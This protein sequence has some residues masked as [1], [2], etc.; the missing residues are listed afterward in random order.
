VAGCVF[1]KGDDGNQ[2]DSKGNQPE[3]SAARNLYGPEGNE[4]IRFSSGNDFEFNCQYSEDGRR[5][6]YLTS[7]LYDDEDLEEEGVIVQRFMLPPVTSI[8]HIMA[9]GEAIVAVRDKDHAAIFARGL[10]RLGCLTPEIEA[11]LEIPI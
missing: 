9:D 3:S 4:S 10:G 5:S 11:A 8:V 6:F 7:D 1:Q 2:P